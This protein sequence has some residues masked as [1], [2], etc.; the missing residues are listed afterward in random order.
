MGEARDAAAERG[1]SR[2]EAYVGES[3][4]DSAAREGLFGYASVYDVR[5]TGGG[6]RPVEQGA[7]RSSGRSASHDIQILDH[8]YPVGG[9]VGQCQLVAVVEHDDA[10]RFEF[11]DVGS[12]GKFQYHWNVPLRFLRGAVFRPAF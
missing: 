7:C 2:I 4:H 12:F 5:G 9:N 11:I 3:R 6:R 8:I 1:V 10:C